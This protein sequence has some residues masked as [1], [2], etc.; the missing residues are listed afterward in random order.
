MLPCWTIGIAP[1]SSLVNRMLDQAISQL[2]KNEQPII[3][4]DRGCHC[5]WTGWIKRM[6]KAGLNVLC[7][8]NCPHHH[9]LHFVLLSK[10]HFMKERTARGIEGYG[11]SCRIK[12]LFYLR[13]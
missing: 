1:D 2:N 8:K 13:S 12:G 6:K 11:S 3:H 7:P 10:I 4:S 9:M 5:Q